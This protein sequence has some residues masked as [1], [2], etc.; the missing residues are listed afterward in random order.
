M[1]SVHKQLIFAIVFTYTAHIL[2]TNGQ[3]PKLSKLLRRWSQESV[4]LLRLG[5]HL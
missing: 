3:L 2:N 1:V 4:P 5:A